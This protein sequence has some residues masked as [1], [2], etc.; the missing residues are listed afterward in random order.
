KKR[1]A[2]NILWNTCL[3]EGDPDKQPLSELNHFARSLES[4]SL[5]ALHV[6]R[7]AVAINKASPIDVT[8]SRIAQK[9][10]I[11]VHLCV[12]LLRQL[13]SCDFVI[14][15]FGGMR[16]FG[17]DPHTV[18]VRPLAEKFLTYVI[19]GG[20]AEQIEGSNA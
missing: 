4:L 3:K 20:T 12:A 2:A 17:T 10:G 7:E 13:D 11:S 9:L 5:D 19:D 18:R 8:S 14:V 1:A 15:E 6:L 16:A